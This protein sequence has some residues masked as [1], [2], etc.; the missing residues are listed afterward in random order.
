MCGVPQGSVLSPKLFIIYINNLCKISQLPKFVLSADD[1]NILGVGENLQQLLDTITTEFIKIKSQFDINKLSLNLSKTNFIIF[2]NREI[3]KDVRINVEGVSIERVYETK[4]LGVT[5]NH[6]ICWKS[7]IKKISTKI[8]RNIAIIAKLRYFLSNNSLHTL[9]CSLALPYLSY[10][11]EVWGNTYR[12]SLQPLFRLQKRAIRI[13]HNVNY[14]EH[15][16]P[17]F[18]K[19]RKIK[20]NEIIEF[21]TAQFM[22]KARN[23]LLPEQ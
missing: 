18:I 17:L 21:M 20:L 2:G 13:I 23:N 15:T 16:N 22:Y 4:F 8:S 11:A 6:K 1:T 14:I 3:D 5:V 9:F 10:C 7:H 12:S 19:A